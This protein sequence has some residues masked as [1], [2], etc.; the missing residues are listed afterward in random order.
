[1]LLA[2]MSLAALEPSSRVALITGANKGIGKEIARKLAVGMP[3]VGGSGF[4][5]GLTTI[6]A[7]RDE[8]LGAAA[9][10]E[11]PGA[12]VCRCDL[13][14]SASIEATRA[15]VEREY[16]RLDVLVNNA[17]VCYNDATLYGK[18]PYTPFEEQAGIT[19]RTNFF[20]SLEVTRALLP[21]LRKSSSPRIINVASAAGRLRGSQA[22]Q[23]KV[24][25]PDLTVE[26]LEELMRTFV[27]DA[28]AGEHVANGWPNT[29]YG[30]SKLGL[31]AYTEVLAREEAG[32]MVNSVDPGFCATDQNA[33][34]GH[35]SAEQGARTATALA[36]LP[37][38][39]FVSG[40]HWYEG[41][42][43]DWYAS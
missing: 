16:G 7:C 36:Q 25:S 35:I 13:T 9:A 42:E 28:E 40:R 20:G 18:V 30:M 34:Q 31:I 33:N 1:M 10:S 27:R 2:P 23:D 14:D 21:L 43:I 6:L 11:I 22:L 17:A 19:V 39:K 4:E 8:E 41:R 3:A 15:F 26:A 5:P 37:A 32:I 12:V 24:T 29:C 38:E